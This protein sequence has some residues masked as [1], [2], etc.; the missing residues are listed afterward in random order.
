MNQLFEKLLNELTLEHLAAIDE[1]LEVDKQQLA[2]KILPLDRFVVLAA[3]RQHCRSQFE[4]VRGAQVERLGNR[5]E[6]TILSENL[7]YFS[8]FI[9]V[10]TCCRFELHC[11]LD[12]EALESTDEDWIAAFITM[13]GLSEKD[14]ELVQVFRGEAALRHLS[15]TAL[16]G[17]SILPGEAE[18]IGQLKQFY[19]RSIEDNLLTRGSMLHRIYQHVFKTTKHLR[20]RIFR[21]GTRTQ[22]LPRIAYDHMVQL[23]EE[24]HGEPFASSSSSVIGI[25]GAGNVALNIAHHLI[26][27]NV[28]PERLLFF[29]R[30]EERTRERPNF[31]Q[32]S[33]TC[34][35]NDLMMRIK[36]REMV[37]LFGAVTHPLEVGNSPEEWRDVNVALPI[38]DLSVPDMISQRTREFLPNSVRYEDFEIVMSERQKKDASVRKSLIEARETFDQLVKEETARINTQELLRGTQLERF[39]RLLNRKVDVLV[40]GSLDELAR[41]VEAA[42]KREHPNLSTRFLNR[43]FRRS[44]RELKAS[45]KHQALRQV[46]DHI[47]KGKHRDTPAS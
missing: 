7:S 40:D 46:I 11:L 17:A 28:A 12:S 39:R 43:E 13:L 33:Q 44:R 42:M 19:A 3:T 31:P 23:V 30:N 26:R 16:G 34:S 2:P 27:H 32:A 22:S 15:W 9:P 24:V 5:P 18:I 37:G 35:V 20:E 14:R 21:G 36:S 1:S 45:L 38:I 41:R 4:K 29:V 47:V 10:T 25:V 6:R 8:D